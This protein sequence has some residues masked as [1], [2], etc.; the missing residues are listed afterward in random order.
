[1]SEPGLKSR[2]GPSSFVF[3]ASFLLLRV[4]S[5][6]SSRGLKYAIYD[7]SLS[8]DECSVQA[9]CTTSFGPGKELTAPTPASRYAALPGNQR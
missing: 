2:R 1:M 7:W 5:P 9:K 8:S 6:R 4:L 3:I